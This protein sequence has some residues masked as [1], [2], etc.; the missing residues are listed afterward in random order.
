MKTL[1]GSLWQTLMTA[2]RSWRAGCKLRHHWGPSRDGLK[3]CER[4]GAWRG[5]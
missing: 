3:T 2:R 4:C 5:A 1:I